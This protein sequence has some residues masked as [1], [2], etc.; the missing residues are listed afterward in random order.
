MYVVNLKCY[1]QEFTVIGEQD[2]IFTG[3]LYF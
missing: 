3:D 2:I 1:V